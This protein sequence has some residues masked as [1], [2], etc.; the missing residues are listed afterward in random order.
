MQ[1]RHMVP[2]ARSELKCYVAYRIALFQ[3]TLSNLQCNFT[4]LKSFTSDAANARSLC[5]S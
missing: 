1:D 3:L 4:L 2:I 5:G